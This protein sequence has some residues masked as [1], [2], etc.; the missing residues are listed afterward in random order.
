VGKE[1]VMPPWLVP[2]GIL[3][4]AAALILACGVWLL[5]QLEKKKKF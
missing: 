3:L 4:G 5:I 1:I 2:V